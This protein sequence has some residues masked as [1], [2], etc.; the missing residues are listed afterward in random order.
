M[1]GLVGGLQR[2]WLGCCNR[3]KTVVY[4]FN[5]QLILKFILTRSL[6]F[7]FHPPRIYQVLKLLNNV[8][9]GWY[10]IH[11]GSNKFTAPE[12]WLPPSST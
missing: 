8:Y 1:L 10:N 2:E 4:V 5:G 3:L 11:T 12:S 7:S 9:S 6:S